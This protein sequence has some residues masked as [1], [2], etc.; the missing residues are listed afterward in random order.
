MKSD[1]WTVAGQ[2]AVKMAKAQIAS[3]RALDEKF[4][5][6]V[7]R[8]LAGLGYESGMVY[9]VLGRLRRVEKRRNA[10]EE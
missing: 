3:G 10:A 7:G 1:D 4:L 6:K 8:R 9:E 5:A 2:V